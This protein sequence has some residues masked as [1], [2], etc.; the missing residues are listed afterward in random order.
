VYLNGHLTAAADHLVSL[1]V[2]ML[3]RTL[4]LWVL[5]LA[6]NVRLRLGRP[7]RQNRLVLGRLNESIAA[8]PTV[9]HRNRRLSVIAEGPSVK[10]L[11]ATAVNRHLESKGKDNLD[12]R[13]AMITF[14]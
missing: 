3:V 13:N 5:T 1:V 7:C 12:Y 10:R 9:L 11:V 4:T 2:Q 14:A 8:L 6:A